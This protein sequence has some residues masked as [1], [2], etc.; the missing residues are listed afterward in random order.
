VKASQRIE[1]LLGATEEFETPLAAVD[2]AARERNLAGMMSMAEELGIRLRP[3][4]KTHKSVA[5]ARRQL[6][7]GAGGLTVA[8]LQ[9]ATVFSDGGINDILL[10]HIPVGAAKRRRLAALA[11]RIH[12]LAVAIDSL[13]VAVGLPR[14]VEILWEVDTGLHRLGTPPGAATA[15]A[16][17]ALLAHVD[18]DRFRGL[19]THGGHAYRARDDQGLLAA[20]QE[21][22][23]LLLETAEMLRAQGIK[24]GEISVGST[25]TSR[26]WRQILGATE[27]RPGTYVYGDA[28]Q[29]QMG[30]Q[31]IEDCAFFVVAT[32]ISTPEAGRA[33]VDAGTKALSIDLRVP[34]IETFGTVAGHPSLRL[35]RLSEEHGVLVAD[36]ATGLKIGDRVAIIPNHVC[37]S[38][39]LHEEVLLVAEDGS[40]SWEAIEARGWGM[41]GRRTHI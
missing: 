7:L 31:S 5:V 18:A 35:D 38:V 39:N 20:A 24:V 37:T 23:N 25:P 41:A 21:E 36:A 27:I 13:E 3:H 1:T 12:R 8:T 9:E 15:E 30:S 19:I 16:V 26:F 34:G 2:N 29:V 17:Q 10:A 33:V 14:S 11:E 6:D 32:V 4:A 40:W 22:T 28:N